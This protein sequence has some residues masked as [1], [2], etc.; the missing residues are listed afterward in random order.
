MATVPLMLGLGRRVRMADR[1]S[2]AAAALYFC[3]PVVGV[4]GTSAYNDAAM[5]FFTLATLLEL[6]LWKQ[7][8]EDRYLLAAGL[9]AGFC[10]ALK[11]NGILVPLLASLFVFVSAR[12]WRP[13]LALGAAALIVIAPLMIRNTLVAGNPIS[14]LGNSIFPTPYFHLTME[15]ALTH[16]WRHYAAFNAHSCAAELTS[17]SD[18]R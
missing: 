2:A 17:R 11:M 13:L 15:Q 5:V 9:L 6:L 12:R 10:Y 14:P 18:F 7:E 3:A 16:D 4:A 1:L 8:S